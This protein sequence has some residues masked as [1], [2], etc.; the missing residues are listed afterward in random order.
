[1]VHEDGAYGPLPRP[2]VNDLDGYPHPVESILELGH[3]PVQC[4]LMDG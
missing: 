3:K 4:Q 2:P 1:M